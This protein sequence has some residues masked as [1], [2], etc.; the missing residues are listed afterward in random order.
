MVLNSSQLYKVIFVMRN[1]F[2]DSWTIVSSLLSTGSLRSHR[3]NIWLLMTYRL[4]GLQMNVHTADTLHT[5]IHTYCIFIPTDEKGP[6]R[7]WKNLNWTIHTAWKKI[8][9]AYGWK[10]MELSWCEHSHSHIF[11]GEIYSTKTKTKNSG[12]RTRTQHFCSL[13]M[14]AFANTLWTH[15]CFIPI[16]RKLRALF[17]CAVRLFRVYQ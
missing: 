11:G 4:D 16:V 3:G 14:G 5:Y 17:K 1:N 13:I 2:A 12:D 10:K 9:V 8:P 15:D 6:G 7:I